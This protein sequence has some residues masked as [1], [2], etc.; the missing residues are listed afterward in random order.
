MRLPMSHEIYSAEEY[1][2]LERKYDERHEYL[3]GLIYEMAGE[4]P[5]HGK[6][7]V[8]L[9]RIISTQLLGKPCQVFSNDMKVRSGPAPKRGYTTKGLFSYPDLLVVC[10]ELKLQDEHRDVL[11]NP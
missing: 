4:S 1:L 10:G 8:N 7:C 11:L 3:D 5:E 2:M 6:I 9:T